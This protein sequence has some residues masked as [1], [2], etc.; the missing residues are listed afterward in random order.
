MTCASVTVLQAAS[1]YRLSVTKALSSG[2]TR[3]VPFED[4]N[5]VK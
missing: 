3:R 5:P 4:G 2:V 1:K